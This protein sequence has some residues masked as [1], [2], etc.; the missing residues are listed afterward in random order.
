VIDDAGQRIFTGSARVE[1]TAMNTAGMSIVYT[2]TFLSS[3]NTDSAD[4]ARSLLLSP[5]LVLKNDNAFPT[6]SAHVAFVS[7][8]G[9]SGLGMRQ[10]GRSTLGHEHVTWQG[11]SDQAAMIVRNPFYVGAQGL[12]AQQSAA[13]AMTPFTASARAVVQLGSHFPSPY[14]V[15]PDDR[16]VLSVSKTR[17]AVLDGVS[18]FSGSLPHDVSLLAGDINVTLYGC[19]VCE[20]EEHH[21]LL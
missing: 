8:F 13:L 2:Q 1:A 5:Q 21:D 18:T 7:P 16:L 6:A 11:M 10:S 4:A 15:M 14:L 20:G 17:P 12:N 19:H 9:R 3:S